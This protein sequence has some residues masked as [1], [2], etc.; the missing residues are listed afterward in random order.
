MS[1]ERAK[2]LMACRAARTSAYN[3]G[4]HVDGSRMRDGEGVH[5]ARLQAAPFR[6]REVPA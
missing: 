2:R 1:R 6:V 3:S 5:L 4:A